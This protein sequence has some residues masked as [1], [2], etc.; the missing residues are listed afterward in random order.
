MLLPLIAALGLAAAPTPE[1]FAMPPGVES[2]KLS[3]DGG[4]LALVVPQGDYESRLL[5][6]D[7]TTL[8]PVGA[9]NST[10]RHQVGGYWWVSDERLVIAEASKDGGLDEPYLTGRLLAV[11]ADGKRAIV[12]YGNNGEQQTGTRLRTNA[13]DNGY[14]MLVDPLIDDPQRAVIAISPFTRE[15]PYTEVHSVDVYSGARR[16]LARAPFAGADFLLDA[17]G[18]PQFAFGD[19]SEGWHQLY[20]RGEYKSW[21]L[22]NDESESGVEVHPLAPADAKGELAVLVRTREGPGRVVRWHPER[23]ELGVLHQPGYA[24]PRTALLGAHGSQVYG[25]IAAEGKERAVV[26]DAALPEGKLV[27]A[28]QRS[29]ED[30]LVE[31]I[32]FSRDGDKL[33]FRV[34]SDRNS[35]EYFLYERETG[36]ARF[37]IARD[38]WAD[39]EAMR[40]RESVQ[41]P[42][43]DGRQ[44]PAVLTLAATESDAKPPLVL[45]IHGGPHGVRDSWL[46]DPWAQL[47]ATR[48]YTVLQVDYR[49]SGGYGQDFETAGYR[50]WGGA[51]IDDLI[52]AT[53]WVIAQGHADGERVCA[54]GASF[55]GYA[56]L[57]L[58]ARAPELYDCALS[59]AGLSDLRLMHRK[60]DIQQTSHGENYLERAIGHEEA[61]LAE[62][63][64]VSHAATIEAAVMLVHGGE[65]LRVPLAHAKAMKKALE[66]IGKEVEWMVED[67]EAHGFYRQE[68]VAEFHRRMLAFLARH[69]QREGAALAV[70]E[71]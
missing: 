3:P 70:D 24:E 10:P 29:F 40:P 23:G 8:K 68:H 63:S 34:R 15:L 52:D 30:A 35:G 53:R 50:Q 22:V 5:I 67:G 11:N 13:D 26:L 48:G 37:L 54:V 36:K 4:K 41:I 42:A 39:P 56:S 51:I 27:A 44:I 12:L 64:P 69:L 28:L 18:M 38:E 14:A 32:S 49:G 65:D 25:L 71:G 43:R 20:Q 9:F 19:N 60:G 2:M 66:E 1:Q 17:Q 7:A 61:Q 45:L 58:A 59:Y 6:L 21:R 33:L 46:F 47:L 31:P 57:M 62:Y 16:K 55:G